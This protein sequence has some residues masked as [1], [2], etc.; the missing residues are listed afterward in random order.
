[1]AAPRRAAQAQAQADP[2]DNDPSEPY[3]QAVITACTNAM[4]DYSKNLDVQPNEWLTVA[5][6]GSDAPAGP[7]LS[8][9]PA[10]RMLRI[11]GSDLADY[12]AS[13]ITRAEAIR[14]VEKREF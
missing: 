5:L 6:R 12:L 4:L 9:E 10:V 3:R 2:A 1:N 14:R 7:A 11:K 13:R 8:P